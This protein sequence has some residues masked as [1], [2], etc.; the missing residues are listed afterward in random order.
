LPQ[1]WRSQASPTSSPS[2]SA[3]F[4]FATAGQLSSASG[5]P[6]W[7]LSAV[8]TTAF[9]LSQVE[10]AGQSSAESQHAVIAGARPAVAEVPAAAVGVYDAR[11]ADVFDATSVGHDHG[12]SS[13]G[14]NGS[15]MMIGVEPPPN[16]R[17]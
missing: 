10:P 12:T 5:V 16:R 4:A 15:S 6:S 17:S 14:S 3:W 2:R 9:R 8:V 1:V 11:A 7:S 13:V